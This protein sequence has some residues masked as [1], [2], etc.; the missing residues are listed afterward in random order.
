MLYSGVAAGSHFSE[1]GGGSNFLC[2]PDE[3]EFLGTTSGVQEFRA[4]LYGTE[5]KTHDAPTS[6]LGNLFNHYVPCSVCHTSARGDVIMIPAKVSCPSSWTREYYGYLMANYHNHYRT[7]FECVDVSAESVTG[8][9]ASRNAALFYFTE[10][11]CNGIDCPPYTEGNE[12]SCVVC[13]K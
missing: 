10:V 5:Y 13:T 6:E 3:P 8:S 1:R 9:A 11:F 12:L 7:T 4:R 2:L